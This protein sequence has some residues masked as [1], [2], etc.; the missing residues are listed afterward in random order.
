MYLKESLISVGNKLAVLSKA[1][2][3]FLI[4]DA[5]AV[6]INEGIT[7]KQSNST[8]HPHRAILLR[9]LEKFHNFP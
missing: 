5:I 1:K 4:D 7:R 6:I 8:R 3:L 9:G 2:K